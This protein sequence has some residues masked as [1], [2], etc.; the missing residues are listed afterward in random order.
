MIIQKFVI[1]FRNFRLLMLL[2]YV[3]KFFAHPIICFS[4]GLRQMIVLYGCCLYV[5]LV[6]IDRLV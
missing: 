3:H 4:C 6:V 2:I 1:I 5:N